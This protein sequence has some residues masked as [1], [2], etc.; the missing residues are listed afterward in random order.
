MLATP[1]ELI[2]DLEGTLQGVGFRP[3]LQRLATAAGLGGFAQNRSGVVRVA[4]R[5]PADRVTE[6]VE[7]LAERL[8]RQAHLEHLRVVVDHGCPSS[9]VGTFEILPSA[10]DARPRIS[11]PADLVTCDAC[12]RDVLDPRSRFF[13]YPFTTCTDCGPRYTVVEG[14]PYDRERTSLRAFPMCTT[15]R[16]EYESPLSRRFHAESLACPVCGPRLRLQAPDGRALAGDPLVMARF[17]IARGRIVAVRGLGGFLL[18]VNPRDRR[19]L[20]RL[21]LRKRRPHKPFA[22]L[23]RNLSDLRVHARI[24]REEARWLTASSGPIV[25]LDR[26]VHPVRDGIAWDLVAPDTNTVGAMLPTSALHLLLMEPLPGDRTPAFDLLVLT[27]GNARAEPIAIG[28]DEAL[29]RLAGIADLFLTHD[30]E[31]VWRVD[32]SI[33][34]L[35]DGREQLWRRARGFAPATFPRRTSSERCVLAFGADLKNTLA[36]GFEDEIVLSQHVGDLST[37]EAIDA[38]ERLAETLPRYFA[39]TPDVVAV[40]LHPDFASTRL[41][42][43]YAAEHGLPLVRVPHH[44]AHAAAALEEMGVAR[45]LAIVFDGTGFGP[46]GSIWGAELFSVETST[47]ERLGSFV[48]AALPGGDA[49]VRDPV[50]QL[51]GRWSAWDGDGLPTRWLDHLGI[52]AHAWK[53][54]RGQVREAFLAPSTHAAGRVFDAVAAACGL[55]REGATYEGRGPIRL[56]T[57]AEGGPLD[58]RNGAASWQERRSVDDAFLWIDWAPCFRR[59]LDGEPPDE[60]RRADIARGLHDAM[61]DAVVRLAEHGREQRAV[62][63][64][65]LCGGVFQNRLLTRWARE[66]LECR[67]FQVFL[68]ARVPLNDGGIAFGQVVVATMPGRT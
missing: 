2:L 54:W 37:P 46:D 51:P 16:A 15:C 58:L 45:A 18:A 50:R 13:G 3:A 33:V 14:M 24:D 32:D 44:H 64:V 65:V 35:V 27:S 12:R 7:H 11:I 40:D 9:E 67:G 47:F 4:L 41:G 8:P 39:R 59:L 21:R 29:Q 56:E 17:A 36:L 23:A 60:L 28:N 49:A 10:K 34:R 30:R 63:R 66:R 42:E 19:A 52:E 53:S 31:I 61:A 68:P 5:G 43:R 1:R 25:V 26:L 38:A 20:E 48:S 6:F 62:N 55:M 57:L 22:L